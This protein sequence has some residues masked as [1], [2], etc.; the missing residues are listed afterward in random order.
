MLNIRCNIVLVLSALA[1]LAN[2]CQND[3]L[4]PENQTSG[5]RLAMSSDT[6]S[7]RTHWNGETIMWSAGDVIGVSYTFDGQWRKRLFTSSALTEDCHTAVFETIVDVPSQE[8]EKSFYGIYPIS[9]VS[10]NF[11]QAPSVN[12]TIPDR[13]YPTVS[14]Y[15]RKA[16]LMIAKSSQT[17]L[18]TPKEAIPMQWKRIVAHADI[19]LTNLDLTEGEQIHTVTLVADEDAAITG[20]FSLDINTGEYTPVQPSNSLTLNPSHAVLDENGQFNLWAVLM[21]AD[22]RSLEVVVQ[23]DDCMYIRSIPSCEMCFAANV[24]H[25]LAID[26]TEAVRVSKDDAGTLVRRS[27][28]RMFLTSSDIPSVRENAA[29]QAKVIYD[30]MKARIDKYM[31]TPIVFPDPLAA[32][33]EDNDNHEVGFRAADAAMVWLISGDRTYLEHTKT[34]LK[35]LNGYYR[36]RVDNDLNIHWYIYSQV[37]ALCAYDWIYNDLTKDERT[38]IGIPLYEVMYDIAWH[39]SGL[40]KSRYREN[41]SAPTTGCYGITALPWYISLAFYGDGIDDAGCQEMFTSG[42]SFHSRMIAHRSAMAGENGGGA[43]ACVGYSFGYYPIADFNFIRTYRSAT[44]VDVSDQ[45]QYVL[46]YLDYLDWSR[47]PDEDMEGSA[48]QFGFGDATHSTC[49]LPY[50]DINYHMY[51]IA[52]LFGEKYPE[53]LP[54]LSGVLSQFTKR[55]SIDKFPFIRLLQKTRPGGG[56][57]NTDDSRKFVHFDTM[58]QLYMRSGTGVD[59]TYAM[60][61]SGGLSEKHK[62]YDNN[63]FVLYKHGFRAL[64][65][66]SRPEPGQHLSHYYA[67]T[68]AHNCITIRKPAEVFP[69]YWGSLAPG[70]VELPVPNDGGQTELLASQVKEIVETADYVYF[71]SDATKSYSSSKV[72]LVMREFVWCVPDVFVVFDRVK[73]V[74]ASYPKTWLYHTASEPVI[75]GNEFS[76]TSQG[77]KSIC[78]TLFPADARLEKIGGPG[79]QFW[80][81]GRNWPIPADAGNG[82]PENTWPLVGQ[83]RMEVTPGI[84]RAEDV[85][86]HI[87]QVGDESLTSLP[88][89]ETFETNSE[90]GAEF[91]YGGKTWRLAFD[92]SADYGCN[93]E[94]K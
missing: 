18:R 52:D 54:R 32:T 57:S 61:V 79:K 58:G 33:G 12:V 5:V 77:G 80:S 34:I 73:S 67:R 31:L 1:L 10:D 26:M 30:E 46:R 64:D 3:R 39:R 91:I 85:F 72:S 36:L 56:A 87:I 38:E 75:Y 88:A 94:V 92:R 82:V 35:A 60:F 43:N 17:Y 44:G 59:D 89:T 68:V 14:S 4:I 83:W 11:A 2:A 81:D 24:R 13:Q 40:R 25:V 55:R 74:S 23:T 47:L 19:T 41:I 42:Y 8:M 49:R 76:E 63:N 50:T 27:H 51:E 93:I 86:M 53:C 90:I 22:V 9:C 65:S 7:S 71:A 28:P 70:E 21:P 84:A 48:R 37:C 62:H 6:P 78:R 66:G 45:M 69:E 15:D 29:G 16:D 20:R